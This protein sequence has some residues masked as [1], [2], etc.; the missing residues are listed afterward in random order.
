MF[1]FSNHL[2]G[3]QINNA[4]PVMKETIP[5]SSLGYSTNNQF[6]AFPP[7]MSDGRAVIGSWQPESAVNDKILKSNNIQT[8]WQYREFIRKNA[9]EIMDFNFREACNDNGYYIRNGELLDSGNTPYS[10]PQLYSSLYDNKSVS[11]V[12][13]SDLKETYL[14]REQLEA[15]KMVPS[16][17]QEQIMQSWASTK[18]LQKT[19]SANPV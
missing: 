18:D 19:V 11:G 7:K 12:F 5:K 9:K 13:H 15:R 3:E 17:T 14:S 1:S 8:N 6:N 2:N 16:M 4:Y 10:T